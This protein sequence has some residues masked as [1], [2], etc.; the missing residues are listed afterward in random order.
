MRYF[1]ANVV[2]LLVLGAAISALAVP[3]S[4]N[5]DGMVT[6][7]DPLLASFFSVGDSMTSSF[8]YE[9][10]ASPYACHPA[11]CGFLATTAYSSTVGGFSGVGSSGQVL[12]INSYPFFAP[13]DVIA[14][15]GTGTVTPSL[16]GWNSDRAFTVELTDSTGKAIKNEFTL[17]TKLKVSDFDSNR[18]YLGFSRVSDGQ[19]AFVSGTVPIPHMFWPTLIVMVGIV[20]WEERRRR[21]KCIEHESAYPC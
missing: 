17:P 16:P 14:V 5:V 18:W 3:V 10:S 19:F 8:T 13:S 1:V 6:S 4:L 15:E 11:Q 7:V 9:S 12:L 20:L 2:G 21:R